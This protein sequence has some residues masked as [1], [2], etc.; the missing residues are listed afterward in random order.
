MEAALTRE[1]AADGLTICDAR[2]AT[3]TRYRHYKG[4][5]YEVLGEARHSETEEDLVLYRP[6]QNTSGLWV[7]P[8][9]MFF[10]TVLINGVEQARFEPDSRCE[11][12]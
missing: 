10:A 5:V 6:V 7:R 11:S 4:G 8:K 9:T 1:L 3:G 12:V 2:L